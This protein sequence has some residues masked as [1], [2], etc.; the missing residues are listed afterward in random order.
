VK[1]GIRSLCVAVTASALLFSATPSVEAGF[2]WGSVLGSVIGKAINNSGGNNSSNGSNGGNG[3]LSNQKHAVPN[4]NNNEKAFLL[5]IE[6]NDIET[7]QAMLD[8]GVDI[9]G[10]YKASYGFLDG[11]LQYTPFAL[12]LKFNNRNMMQFLLERGANVNGFYNFAGN[13][14]CHIVSAG[15]YGDLSLLEYLHNWG[16]DINGTGTTYGYNALDEVY[17]YNWNSYRRLLCAKYLLEN[18]INP[19]NIPK[20]GVPIF[21]EA[22]KKSDYEMIDLLHSY[23]A[24]INIRDKDGRSAVDIALKNHNLQ[25]YKQLQELLAQGQQPSK[26]REIKEAARAEANAKKNRDTELINYSKHINKA[27]ASYND[28]VNMFNTDGEI[29]VKGT[30][31]D[32]VKKANK[33]LAKM[34]EAITTLEDNNL[35]LTNCTPEEKEIMLDWE[36]ATKDSVLKNKEFIQLYTIDRELTYEEIVEADNLANEANTLGV[37]ANEKKKAAEDFL[38]LKL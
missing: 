31:K 14:V 27:I 16:A 20:N 24:N 13:Y 19:D 6:K 26:Y 2:D 9:N 4:P 5:A 37:Y 30:V 22:A 17:T 11:E 1:K 34:N 33:I 12:A 28:A 7:A 10:V 15:H 21:I 3:G 32:R 38:H 8:A 25:L 23:G 29:I 35:P 18:G 36:Q